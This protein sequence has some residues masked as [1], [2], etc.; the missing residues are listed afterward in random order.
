MASKVRRLESTS[1]VS[2]LETG[3]LRIESMTPGNEQ[4]RMTDFWLGLLKEYEES[5]DRETEEYER[6]STGNDRRRE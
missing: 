6:S 3:L 1:I 5:Y 2:R 4:E